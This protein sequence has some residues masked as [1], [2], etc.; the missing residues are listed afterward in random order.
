MLL[1][2]V[3]P[4]VCLLLAACMAQLHLQKASSRVQLT[5]NS[6]ACAALAGVEITTQKLF[7]R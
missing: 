5:P 2:G 3:L 1:E 6:C 4:G 7:G